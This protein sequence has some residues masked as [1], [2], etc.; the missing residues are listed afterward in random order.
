MQEW[1]SV[2]YGLLAMIGILAFMCLSMSIIVMLNES[3]HKKH[4]HSPSRV[5]EDGLDDVSN[6]IEDK[7]KENTKNDKQH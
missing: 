1:Y 3:G 4:T 2:F 6:D 5:L 7:L